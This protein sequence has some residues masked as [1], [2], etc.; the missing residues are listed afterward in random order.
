M[1]W[2]REQRKASPNQVTGGGEGEQERGRWNANLVTKD[3][4][5]TL[6]PKN[7]YIFYYSDDRYNN[8]ILIFIHKSACV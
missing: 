3:R 7:E 8:I 2:S 6:D 1:A 5:K 4:T